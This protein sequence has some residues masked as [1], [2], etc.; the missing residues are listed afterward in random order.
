MSRAD[1]GWEEDPRVWLVVGEKRGDNAQI[2]NLARAVGWDFEEK[3]IFVKPA[4]AE[5]KPRVRPALDHIDRDR[6]DRLEPPW[7]D[8]VITSGRRLSRV[9][10]WIK[11]ASGGHTKLVMIGKPRRLLDSVD[12]IVIAAHVALPERSNVVRHDLPLMH[13]DPKVLERAAAHWS[14]RLAPRPRPRTALFVGGRTGGLRFDLERARDLLQTTLRTVRAS[15]GSLSVVTSRR[16]PPE[17]VEML[18]RELPEDVGLYVYDPGSGPDENPYHALL[19]TADHFVVTTDS[20]SM[21]VEVA[22][23]GRPLSLYPLEN[24]DSLVEHLLEKLGVLRPL[25]VKVDP[26]PAGGLRARMMYRLGWPIH[27]RD[28]S[29]IPRRLVARGLAVWLGDPP[30]P[31]RPYADDELDRIAARVRALV[32]RERGDAK[33]GSSL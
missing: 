33:P 26:L 20:L 11:K 3:R 7:P 6:S 28:L 9:G 10:L 27:T 23:M 18:R 4:W 12:L 14:D 2:R 13:P 22:R 16:T 19:A 29:A 8:L 21:M 30:L 1:Q 17:V 5:A 15:G 31:P 24:E 32:R 25:S